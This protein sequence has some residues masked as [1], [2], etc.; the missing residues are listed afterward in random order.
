MLAGR[1]SCSSLIPPSTPLGGRRSRPSFGAAWGPGCR[2][3]VPHQSHDLGLGHG[4]NGVFAVGDVHCWLLLTTTLRN[5]PL[6]LLRS[7]TAMMVA[8]IH[9]PPD[10]SPDATTATD[11]SAAS[12]VPQQLVARAD[13][14]S[15]RRAVTERRLGVLG[16]SVVMFLEFL[17]RRLVCPPH[18]SGRIGRSDQAPRYRDSC[19]PSRHRPCGPLPT[20][21]R[22]R[23]WQA[24]VVMVSIALWRPGVGH[25]VEE[26][27][28]MA[29]GVPQ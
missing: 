13:C 16:G 5:S 27:G 25:P 22:W 6:F 19:C 10:T 15:G 20:S 4:F 21:T 14:S 29:A 28:Q 7:S 18:R 1:I 8:G 26:G 3:L 17:G 12:F 11:G 9:R 23:S 24:G 2:I